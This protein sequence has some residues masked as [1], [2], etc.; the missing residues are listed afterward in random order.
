MRVIA[1]LTPVI[2]VGVDLASQ[3]QRTGVAIVSDDPRLV[4][5]DVRV[6]GD[7]DEVIEAIA[8]ADRA[9]VDVPMG[10]PDE[11][12]RLVGAHA[13][14][15]TPARP[16]AEPNWTRSVVLRATDLFVHRQT[17]LV[18][19]SVAADRIAYPALRWVEL[20]A[21]LRQR[22]IRVPRDG[23]GT[24]VEVYPAAALRRWSLPYRRYKGA[25]NRDERTHLVGDLMTRTPWLDWNGHEAACIADDNALDA[26][27]AALVAREASLGG[28]IP[29]PEDT[30]AL[31]EREGW[32][33][34]PTG[35][36]PSAPAAR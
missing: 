2:F 17:G 5:E 18:P 10:W 29:P 22:G 8:T 21:R 13:E 28:C 1:T 30:R 23:S 25:K 4:L 7:D 26:V 6:G 14:R 32:I 9:G 12:V 16:S 19:L 33:W 35:G 3:P 36:G 15:S 24:V 27:L 20:E 31:A 34:L 11:F